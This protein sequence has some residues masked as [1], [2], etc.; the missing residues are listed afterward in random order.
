M[1]KQKYWIAASLAAVLAITPPAPAF[2]A[3]EWIAGEGNETKDYIIVLREGENSSS[4]ENLTYGLERAE[5][6][7]AETQEELAER[8]LLVLSLTPQEA[9]V[10]ARDERVASIEED[11]IVRALESGSAEDETIRL[12]VIIEG[13]PEEMASGVTASEEVTKAG[14]V[15]DTGEISNGGEAAGE[16]TGREGIAVSEEAKAGETED[17]FSDTEPGYE[18]NLAAV[19]ATPEELAEYPREEGVIR[20]AVLDSGTCVIEDLEVQ[21]YVNLVTEEQDIIAYYA[22]GTGHGTAVAGIIAAKDDDEGI[23]GIAPDVTLYSVKVFDQTNEAPV[24]RIIEGIYWAIGHDIDI[25]NMSFGTQVNSYALHQAIQDAYAEGMLL[26]AAAG[27]GEQIEY[28]AAYHEVI[29]V[30]AVDYQ[31]N[32]AEFSAAGEGLELMAPGECVLSDSF[33]GGVMAVDGT[34]IAAPHVAGAAAVLWA[35]DTSKSSDF[36]RQ[37]LNASANRSRNSNSQ[38]YGNGLLDVK[39]AFEI[40]EEFEA[41]YLPGVHEYAGIEENTAEYVE[42]EEPGYVVGSWG[43]GQASNGHFTSIAN[44]AS[45]YYSS[46]DISLMQKVSVRLDSDSYLYKAADC[47]YFHGGRCYE[48]RATQ[49]MDNY[50]NNLIFLYETAIALRDTSASKTLSQQ[51]ALV[52]STA[53]LVSSR[54]KITVKSDF[55]DKVR[56]LLA[57]EFDGFGTTAQ[58][59]TTARNALKVLGAA[60]HLAGDTYAHRSIVPRNSVESTVS[61]SETAAITGNYYNRNHFANRTVCTYT[62]IAERAY[63]SFS[64]NTAEK[65]SDKNWECFKLGVEN[66]AIEFKDIALW[67]NGRRTYYEDNASFYSSRYSVGTNYTVKYL[68]DNFAAD[69]A[70]LDYLVFLPGVAGKTY[71]IRLNN[72]KALYEAVGFTWDSSWAAYTTTVVR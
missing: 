47:T 30:G 57:E 44:N 46:T 35:K 53:I 48:N 62:K 41:A 28:P 68:L 60:I 27:N 22:D 13:K 19:H 36:I 66:G 52:T 33:Y 32:R 24:S 6:C 11:V 65:C 7:S 12:E 64:E 20:V 51:Q 67:A 50:V 39:H 42:N 38:E 16:I 61:E 3:G 58:Q 59:T 70:T 29:A 49:E 71:S 4:I 21:E 18:W 40:Y 69:T 23:I 54:T 2:A 34:S 25:V 72:L 63:N 43:N 15:A 5:S 17:A 14:E 1:K 10:L 9:A 26:V 56:A 8:N 37:L 55:V 31:G 45:S